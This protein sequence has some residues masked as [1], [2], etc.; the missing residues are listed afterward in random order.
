MRG[1]VPNAVAHDFAALL[2]HAAFK[3]LSAE[4]FDQEFLDLST[5][6]TSSEKI[7]ENVAGVVGHAEFLKNYANVP[8][9]EKGLP[10]G[11][12]FDFIE[13]QARVELWDGSVAYGNWK[14]GNDVKERD[15]EQHHCRGRLT[16]GG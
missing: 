7:N 13:S 14:S 1:L 4:T 9:I 8:V 12:L 11:I 6:L 5:K 10:L 15:K 16:R 3:V 2:V